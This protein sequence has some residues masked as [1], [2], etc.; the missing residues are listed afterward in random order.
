MNG[1]VTSLI[2][3]ILISS[4]AYF[5]LIKYFSDL[6]D[7]LSLYHRNEGFFKRVR[8]V[9]KVYAI[10]GLFIAFLIFLSLN[11]KFM[12][13]FL[14]NI[15]ML[16]KF[17]VSIGSALVLTTVTRTLCLISIE[18]KKIRNLSGTIQKE[19]A[20][21]E[22]RERIVSFFFSFFNSSLLLFII[23]FVCI[24]FLG[25]AGTLFEFGQISSSEIRTLLP[26]LAF[27][28]LFSF[29]SELLL[30]TWKVPE[31]LQSS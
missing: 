10:I 24:L 23:I 22:Y 7:Q 12:G 18:S 26:F 21:H 11:L 13:S 2:V 27:P 8:K 31:T 19:R 25:T 20:W 3:I 17:I 4:I 6:V 9:G 16:N 15:S 1:G 30:A 14:A 5:L 29:I 28:W